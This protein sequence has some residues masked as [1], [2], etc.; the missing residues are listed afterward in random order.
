MSKP[1]V[2]VGGTFDLFHYGHMKFLQQAQQHGPVLVSL[3]TDDFASRYKRTPILTLGERMESLAGCKYVDDVCVNIG[4]EDTGVTIDRI[5]DREIGYIAHGDDWTDESLLK[6]LG[7]TKG[8]LEDRAIEML[9]IPYT[10]SVS[11]TDIIRRINGDT[12]SG[13][14]CA[15]R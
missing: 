6:Q 9:Y 4:D 11:S 5:T 13:C 1:W 8:W 15:C 2:Y 3:N 10:Q 12:D 14:D 7:I